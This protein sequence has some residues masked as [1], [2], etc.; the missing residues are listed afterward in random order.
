MSYR[1]GKL[2]SLELYEEQYNGETHH[3]L[4]SVWEYE[5][6]TGR[7][8]LTI[9]K[10]DL[11]NSF[12]EVPEIECDSVC[13]YASC[14]FQLY[15]IPFYKDYL[16]LFPDE[17]GNECYIKELEKFEKEMT[18]KEIEK[19]LGYKIKLVSGNEENNGTNE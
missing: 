19:K 4:K 5:T 18:L 9:P 7:Y 17:Q 12:Y 15:H 8:E 1:N 3:F 2:K 10:I 16:K 11:G 13:N 6:V 14:I